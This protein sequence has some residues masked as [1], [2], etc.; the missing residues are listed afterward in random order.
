MREKRCRRFGFCLSVFV[1]RGD[2]RWMRLF[3]DIILWLLLQNQVKTREVIFK[4]GF[5]YLVADVRVSVVIFFIVVV[6]AFVLVTAAGE[7]PFAI[8]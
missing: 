1:V 5:R 3:L 4:I 7:M 8:S 2:F 6:V